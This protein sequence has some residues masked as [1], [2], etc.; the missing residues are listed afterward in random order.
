MEYSIE[1]N[2]QAA[3]ATALHCKLSMLRNDALTT[4]VTDFRVAVNYG[5]DEL[6][7]ESFVTSICGYIKTNR[8]GK[9]TILEF[10]VFEENDDSCNE[11][12]VTTQ[13]I[14]I[15]LPEQDDDYVPQTCFVPRP[16]EPVWVD[17]DERK[18]FYKWKDSLGMTL[19]DFYNKIDENKLTLNTIA[20]DII[21]TILAKVEP[22][23][24]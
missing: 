19:D 24:E 12:I 23:K 7:D 5:T 9:E 17:F 20:D 10:T 15:N 16:N 13:Y 18:V 8:C 6:A 14:D 4:G 3:L 2:Y 22:S 1:V 11:Y 21:D